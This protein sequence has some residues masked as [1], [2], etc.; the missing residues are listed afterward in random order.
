MMSNVPGTTPLHEIAHAL[1]GQREGDQHRE[2][3]RVKLRE[4][5]G[6]LVETPTAA[7]LR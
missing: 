3:F 6:S 7:D 4:I 2:E 5:G 1:L